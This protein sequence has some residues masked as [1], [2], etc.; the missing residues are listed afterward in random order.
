MRN[1]LRGE[2]GGK[3]KRKSEDTKVRKERFSWGGCDP[4]NGLGP[5]KTVYLKPIRKRGAPSSV[6][7]R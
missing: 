3:V 4:G 7:S 5:Q 1:P 6:S 2:E